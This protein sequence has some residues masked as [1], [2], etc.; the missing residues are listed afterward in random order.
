MGDVVIA[1]LSVAGKPPRHRRQRA[2]ADA[3]NV[4]YEASSPGIPGPTGRARA[5]PPALMGD[6]EVIS[7]GSTR[8]A[9]SFAVYPAW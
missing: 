7:S 3:A 2:L 5:T 9:C 4:Y 6:A 8:P 1:A